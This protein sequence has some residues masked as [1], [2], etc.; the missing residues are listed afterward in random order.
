MLSQDRAEYRGGRNNNE[1]NMKKIRQIVWLCRNIIDTIK[2][3]VLNH[4]KE[5]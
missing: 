3:A 5:E 2:D 1:K 4:K